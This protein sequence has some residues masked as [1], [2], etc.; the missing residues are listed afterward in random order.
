MIELLG[1]Y[2]R[3]GPPWP[4]VVLIIHQRVATEGHPY[5]KFP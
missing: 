5:N 3:G 1:I 4:P 2:C